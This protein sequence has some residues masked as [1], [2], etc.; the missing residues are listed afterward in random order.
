MQLERLLQG[1]TYE[2]VQGSRDREIADISYHSKRIREGSLFVCIKG[3]RSDG[4]DYLLRAIEH[5]A[6]AAVVDWDSLICVGGQKILY[7]SEGKVILEELAQ[8]RDITFII[9]H[10]TRLALAQISAAYFDY[11]ARRLKMVGITGTKGKTTTAFMTAAILN[12]AGIRVG[13]IGTIC[14]MDGVR[15]IPADHTTP[16]SYELQKYL[17]DMVKNGCRCCVMEVSSQGIKQQRVAGITFDVGVFLNIEPDHIGEG[18][19]A[20]FEEY[21]HCKAKLFSHCRLGIVNAD[22]LHVGH[23]LQGHTC[24]VETFSMRYPARVM[25]EVPEFSMHMGALQS[26]FVMRLNRHFLPVE[27]GLPGIFN[28]YNALAAA[29]I[30]SHFGVTGREICDGLAHTV[31]PGRCENVKVSQEYVFLIDYA[32]NEMSLKNLLETLRDFKPGRLVVVF[33]CGGNRS[34]LRRTRMGETAG[35]LADLTIITSDN[36][37][38]EEPEAIIADIEDG[39]AVTGGRYVTIADR[40][41]AVRYALSQ[42]RP[43]DII[44]LAGKGHEDYQ[45]IRGVKYPM[46]DHDLVKQALLQEKLGE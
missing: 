40:G 34:M 23:I 46:R 29:A 18:E 12:R 3:L 28:V 6:V 43:G 35:H 24:S 5:G 21:L 42:A 16:E 36:P 8:N 41:E 20:S 19:H 32:H 22:D 30:A 14:I 1:I 25:A 44:V 15:Q 33:G 17:A 45:E 10:D 9:V 27:M 7:T 13:M 37:R 26:R 11:P 4:H 2:C 38:W 39:I 31:V